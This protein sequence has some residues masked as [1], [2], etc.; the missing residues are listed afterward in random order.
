MARLRFE[1]VTPKAASLNVKAARG[2]TYPFKDL[3]Q[4]LSVY[5]FKL[6]EVKYTA[7]KCAVIEVLKVRQIGIHTNV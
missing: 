7:Y 5:K 6:L 3:K 4:L 1:T 2:S